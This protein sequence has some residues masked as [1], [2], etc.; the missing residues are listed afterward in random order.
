MTIRIPKAVLISLAVLV[1]AGVG[2]GLYFAFAADAETSQTCLD[3]DSGVEVDCD[4]ADAVSETEYAEIQEEKAE[5]EA[6][7]KEAE[8]TAARCERQVGDVLAAAQELDARLDVGLSLD[9]YTEYVGDIA[10]AHD[11][12]RVGQLDLDCLGDVAVPA[13]RALNHYMRAQQ[14]WEECID[15]FGCNLDSVDPQLQRLWGK[16]TDQVTNADKGLRDLARP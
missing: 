9:E 2:A 10:V 4:H 13:E 6:A 5:E 7:R 15:D 8:R 3:E 1:V 12:V 11:R 14:V 16:A